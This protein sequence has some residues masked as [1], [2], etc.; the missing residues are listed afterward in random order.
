LYDPRTGAFSITGSLETV[1]V[2]A[3]AAVLE[4]GHVLVVGGFGESSAELYWP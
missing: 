4:D 1:R 2:W 3:A